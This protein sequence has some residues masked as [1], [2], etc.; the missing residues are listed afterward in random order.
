MCSRYVCLCAAVFVILGSGSF[1][2][3]QVVSEEPT[4]E[5]LLTDD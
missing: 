1:V 2:S 5:P 3:G 4:S